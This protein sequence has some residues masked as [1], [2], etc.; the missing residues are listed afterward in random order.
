MTYD[1]TALS[2]SDKMEI[3]GYIREDTLETVNKIAKPVNIKNTFYTK[4]GKRCF[5]FFVGLIGFIVTIPINIIIAIITLID[6]GRPIIFK[7][8][9]IGKDGKKFT[10]Y[11]FR[12]MTN[13]VDENGELLPPNQRVTKWGRI[14]RK[15]SLDELMNFISIISGSMSVIGPRPL[16][17]Y[18]AE[19]LNT[20]HKSMYTVRPGL[21]C[22]TLKKINHVLSWQ[23][24]LD[25]YVWYVEN[26]S[27][28]VDIKLLLRVVSLVFDREETDKRSNAS[29]GGFM[30]YNLEG[31]VVYTKNIPQKYIERF[32]KNHGYKDL[33]EAIE[34][35]MI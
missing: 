24:R 14:V 34:N 22:P 26:C 5:D 32:C 18:Y 33:D 17:D 16:P 7:Q 28:L 2:L 19:R 31:D 8:Q 23:E 13:D 10:I 15:T 1:I 3:A 25:N 35:R 21:E 11:K 30:G 12:N 4:Y 9:R 20:R 6:V 29:Y 27:F